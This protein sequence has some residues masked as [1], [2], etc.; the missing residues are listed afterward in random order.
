V[1]SAD[2]DGHRFADGESR[3]SSSE[4]TTQRQFQSLP[5]PNPVCPFNPVSMAE[6]KESKKGRSGMCNFIRFGFCYFFFVFS[7]FLSFSFL[8]CTCVCA[9]VLCISVYV[10]VGC[11]SVF[12]N[13]YMRGVYVCGCICMWIFISFGF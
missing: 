10:G 13:L 1:R 12:K 11:V 4:T 5:E 6:I 2:A 8:V 3:T 7:S 9:C